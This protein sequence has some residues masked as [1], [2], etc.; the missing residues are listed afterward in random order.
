MNKQLRNLIFFAAACVL[1]GIGLGIAV[2]VLQARTGA[3]GGEL[4]VLA[5]IPAAVYAGMHLGVRLRDLPMNTSKPAKVWV[6][7]WR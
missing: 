4:L 1:V 2:M 7:Y 6:K 3:V 5:A